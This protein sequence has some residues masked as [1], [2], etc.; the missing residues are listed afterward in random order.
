MIKEFL[1]HGNEIFCKHP[2]NKITQ[3]VVSLPYKFNPLYIILSI[4]EWNVCIKTLQSINYLGFILGP[5]QT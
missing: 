2:R 5:K 4:V 3:Y 1:L